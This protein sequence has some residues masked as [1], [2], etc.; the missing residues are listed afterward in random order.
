MWIWQALTGILLVVLLGLHMVEQHFI[1]EGGLRT[2]AGV[3]AVYAESVGRGL[4]GGFLL[5]SLSP[6]PEW[7]GRLA[8]PF[9][10]LWN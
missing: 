10:G 9:G 6:T 4:G 1:A 8:L 7:L 2:Y 3:I 5:S